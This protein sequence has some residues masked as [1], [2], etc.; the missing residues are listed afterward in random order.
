MGSCSPVL[1][2]RDAAG[3]GEHPEDERHEEGIGG[4]VQIE[5]HHRVDHVGGDASH[6]ADGEGHR[7]AAAGETG[8]AEMARQFADGL[9]ACPEMRA[10]KQKEACEPH[11]PELGQQLHV[12]V[13]G[14]GGIALDHGPA[15]HPAVV[16]VG[17][18]ASAKDGIERELPEAGF[19]EFGPERDVAARALDA[20]PEQVAP[21]D[22]D[23]HS[24]GQRRGE[25][26]GCQGDRPDVPVALALLHHEAQ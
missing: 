4:N 10:Q 23:I 3:V 17:R 1:L 18:A 2:G 25:N 14:V 15:E 6:G 21:L 22:H 12:V 26:E 16:Q 19:P 20:G 24:E 13:V 8:A 7:V 11:Q 9:P 5:I